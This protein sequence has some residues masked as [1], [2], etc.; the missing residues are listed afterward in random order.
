MTNFQNSLVA[1]IRSQDLDLADVLL[2]LPAT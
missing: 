2:D 1:L